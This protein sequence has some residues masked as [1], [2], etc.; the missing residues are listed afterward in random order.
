[1]RFSLNAIVEGRVSARAVLV[2]SALLVTCL[3]AFAPVAQ[4]KEGT[5]EVKIG[6][7]ASAEL[8]KQY[9][10]V[11]DEAYVGRV[12]RIGQELA[13]IANAQELPATYGSSA[14]K[15][16]TYTFKVLDDKDVNALS[17]PGGFVYV[18]KGLIDYVQSDDELAGVLAHEISHIAHHHMLSLIKEQAKGMNQLAMVLVAMIAARASPENTGN[19]LMGARFVQ[20]A[21]LNGYSRQAEEDA[22]LTGLAL[23]TRSKYNPVGM[24]TFMERLARDEILRPSINWGVYQTHP[25]AA[26]RAHEL[27]ARLIG[28]GIPI[29]R[30][31]VT[32][33]PV[34]SVKQ[35][36][37]DKDLFEVW[38]D[39]QMMFAPAKTD[40][41]SEDR[42]KSIAEHIN[43]LLNEDLR[44]RDVRQ[45]ANP[46]TVTARG[47]LLI[48]VKPE[49]TTLA[50]QPADQVAK[51][52]YDV[53][54]GVL[55]NQQ[56][57]KVF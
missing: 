26:D 9:K 12:T 39:G 44:T 25:F 47:E 56:M 29:N 31:A 8:E 38:L 41:S 43:A 52:A 14:V 53:L 11:T 51:K 4:A 7:E 20:L 50:G 23:L 18:N 13:D 37:K 49:D 34:A 21:R 42:A 33:G 5:D 17:M 27:E 45:S 57:E 40:Q 19:V 1:M 16:F 46:A 30:R 2:A 28:L 55:L 15:K 48:D 24:L 36:E 35:N 54:Y 22:D 10:L 3:F 32:K 6:K